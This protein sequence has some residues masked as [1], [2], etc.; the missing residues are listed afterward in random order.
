MFTDQYAC[1]DVLNSIDFVLWRH[2]H[3]L[4][5]SHILLLDL[6]NWLHPWQIWNYA[7]IT[8]A[9][10][11]ISYRF[12]FRIYRPH[13]ICQYLLA[14]MPNNWSKWLKAVE[15]PIAIGLIVAG[16][17][18]PM[19]RLNLP[20][21]TPVSVESFI[22]FYSALNTLLWFSAYVYQNTW[23]DN[24]EELG[25]VTAVSFD[26]AGNVV[27]FHRVDRI[28]NMKTFNSSN[29]YQERYKGPIRGNTVLGLEAET[30]KVVYKWGKDL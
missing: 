3:V 10:L 27:M 15:P 8:T 18:K 26:K 25:S 7:L 30:G 20:N 4:L 29:V 24:K 21:W 5:L 23:P 28:W 14:W 2:A 22:S 11:I 16:R 1:T 13:G 17:N 19:L 6:A 12:F 9:M